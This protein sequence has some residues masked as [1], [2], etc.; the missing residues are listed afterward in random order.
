MARG[1]DEVPPVF[2]SVFIE[3]MR[4]LVHA[5]RGAQTPTSLRVAA[6][7]RLPLDRCEAT[8]DALADR[9]WVAR[10]GE[11]RWLLACD[12]DVVTAAEVYDGFDQSAAARPGPS[13]AV[14]ALLAGSLA[15]VREALAVPLTRLAEPA[16]RTAAPS[17]TEKGR[18]RR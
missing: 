18:A 16:S 10:T 11:G 3:V 5:Q 13:G 9:G 17:R 2:L 15:G 1:V 7:A 8:L 12:P 4:V 6:H 14:A